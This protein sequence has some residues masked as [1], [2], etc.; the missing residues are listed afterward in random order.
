MSAG[1]TPEGD[2]SF[3]TSVVR[4]LAGALALVLVVAAAF[5]GVGRMQAP[6]GPGPVITDSPGPTSP[7]ASQSTTPSDD[8]SVSTSPTEPTPTE[9][10]PTGSS[11]P[12]PP[13][14]TIAP[15]SISVQVLDAAGDNGSKAREVSRALRDAG[16]RVVAE[17]KARRIYD[18]STAFYTRGH[19]P[20]ARQIAG[21][22]PAFDVVEEKPDTLTDSVNVHVVVGKDYPR[23]G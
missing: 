4:N 14:P 7:R 8:P 22:L 11:E 6:A 2:R 1:H 23:P 9:P 5:W 19:Q 17:S 18:E 3:A 13:P 12:E 21:F 10:S 16:Y 20:A 15:S